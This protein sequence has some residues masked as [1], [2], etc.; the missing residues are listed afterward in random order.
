MP[1][2]QKNYCWILP[3]FIISTAKKIYIKNYDFDDIV[4]IGKLSLINAIYK[5]DNSREF[6]FP[7]YAVNAIKNNYY[8]EIKK[9]AARN[10]ETSLN[11]GVEEDVEFIDCLRAVDDTEE[12]VIRKEM[13]QVVVRCMDKLP[14]KERELISW[15]YIHDKS[16][17]EYAESHS[18]SYNS[19]VKKKGRI[20]ERLKKLISKE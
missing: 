19:I 18:Q 3:P 14:L 5:Y 17:K 8:H 20:I 12:A 4:Q 13:L 11:K 15:F 10:F 2:R 16:I 9:A 7:G 1:G 6:C